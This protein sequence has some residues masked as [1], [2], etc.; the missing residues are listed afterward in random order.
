MTTLEYNEYYSRQHTTPEPIS[1]ATPLWRFL[2]VVAAIHAAILSWLSLRPAL[3]ILPDTVDAPRSIRSFLYHAPAAP[4]ELSAPAN[5][6]AAS[7]NSTPATPIE[8]APATSTTN[9]ATELNQQHTVNPTAPR[10]VAVKVNAPAKVNIRAATANYLQQQRTQVI[11][12]F[13]DGYATAAHPQ[14]QSDMGTPS[15]SLQLPQQPLAE[16][17]GSLDSA[18]DPNRIVKVGSTCYR[19]VKTPTQLNPN[20]ENLGF[21]FKCGQ[22]D[23]ERLLDASL[24]ARIQQHRH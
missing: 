21:P 6:T 10:Q 12:R 2:I 13:D 15:K 4:K 18:L 24:K 14:R 1:T 19:V 11:G 5:T 9:T 8:P 3:P 20:A 7:E 17:N 23:D 22:T 16:R